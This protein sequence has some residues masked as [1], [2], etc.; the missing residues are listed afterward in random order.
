MPDDIS[1][2]E[3]TLKIANGFCKE[4]KDVIFCLEE[5][6]FYMYEKG[7]WNKIFER[8]MH[9]I[10]LTKKSLVKKMSLQ[11]LKNVVDRIATITQVHLENFN[12]DEVVNFENGL[13]YLDTFE[14]KDHNQ[15]VLSTIRIP[16]SY[17]PTAQCPLWEK[18]INEIMENDKSKIQTLQEFF[19]YCLT[20]EVKY[21]KALIMIGEG[22][23]GK[24]TI[25]STLEHMVGTNNCSALSLRHFSD[26]QKT[27]VLKGKLINICGE[28]PKKIEDYEAEFKTIVTGEQL[29]VSPKYVQEYKIRPFCK[30]IMAIN[31]FPHIDD[32]TSA[33]YRRLLLLELKRQFSE[34]EQNTSLREELIPELPGI[35]NWSIVGLSRLRLRGK[36]IVDEYMLQAIE[37]VR[38]SNNPI[39]SW[40][41]DHLMVLKGEELFKGD[42]FEEYKKWSEK[43]GYK[44]YGLAKFGAEVFKIFQKDTDK[45]RRQGHG[46]RK[47]IWPNLALR[48]TENE[49]RASQESQKENLDWTE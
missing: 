12:M 18:T 15:N 45:D 4:I 32:K 19:G 16:Y 49:L 21:E 13:F 7:V 17:S 39:I 9:D 29:T 31:E 47:K 38:E 22:A 1:E 5:K 14:I 30:L 43:S 20:R 48:T 8:E 3:I 44:P 33:F 35:F 41:K 36:F 27:S 25:L 23:N 24:S 46:D 11:G 42:A 6:C 37:N 2:I 34:E 40:A 28:V 10:V 26:P